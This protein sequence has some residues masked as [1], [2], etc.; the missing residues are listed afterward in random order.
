[1]TTSWLSSPWVR[2]GLDRMGYS[3]SGMSVAENAYRPS[4]PFSP[5]GRRGRD[6]SSSTQGGEGRG[7]GVFDVTAGPLIRPSG[8]FSPPGRRRRW[9][10]PPSHDFRTIRRFR[11]WP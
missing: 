10:P 4:V 6:L 11:Y 1:M 3:N 8:T 7:E 2:D 9:A 5:A